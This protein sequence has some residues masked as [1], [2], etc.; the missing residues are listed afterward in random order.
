MT[1]NGKYVAFESLASNLVTP[2]TTSYEIFRKELT[3]PT[4]FYFAEGYSG[5]GFQEYLCLGNPESTPLVVTVTYLFEDDPP[6]EKTYNIG[7]DSRFTANVNAEV[8]P[9]GGVA[10]KCEA[11]TKFIA[12]RPMYF[13]FGGTWK[14]G[15]DSVGSTATSYEWYFAEGYTGAG[16]SEWISVLNPGNLDLKLDLYFQTQE[17]GEK[18]VNS[19]PAPA[20]SRRSYNVN[21]LLGGGSYQTSLKVICSG[22]M[23]VER[24]MYFDYQG[25]GGWGWSGGHCCIGATCLENSFYFAEGTTRSGFEEWLTLQNPWDTAIDVNAVYQLGDGPP[26]VKDYALPPARRSTIY[27]P[28]EVGAEK[29]VSVLLTSDSLFL[30]ERPMYFDYQGMGA[31]GWTGGHCVIGSACTGTEWYFA[32]G[33]TG[34]YFEEWLS[35]QNPGDSAAAITITYYPEGGSGPIVRE[36]VVQPFSRYT[37][38]VNVDAGPDLSLSAKISSTRPVIVER[39][40][41]FNYNG[42]WPGGHDVVGYIP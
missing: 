17:E 31:W 16:F 26:V 32:E 34:Q 15:H 22:E 2:G 38:P 14:G 39:P 21:D 23:V 19:Y 6:V 13:G 42:V 3:V 12:E 30:A 4:T 20:R 28:A 7:P 33:Y 10:I 11:E 18:I 1:S 40:M 25:T 5:D 29:D 27:V 36:H 35:I 41:Y 24:S 8:G 37:I 9:I